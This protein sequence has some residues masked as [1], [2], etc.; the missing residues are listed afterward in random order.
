MAIREARWDC[1][2]CG[3]TGILGRHQACSKCGRSRPA[4]T[5]FYLAEDEEVADQKLVEKAAIG[6]DWVCEFCSSSN[7]AD[8]SVCQSC[9]AP[10]EATSP[11]QQAKEYELG[12]APTAGDMS[13][14]EPQPRPT[15]A[16]TKKKAGAKGLPAALIGVAAFLF[17]CIC[18][19]GAFFIFGGR[20]TSATVSGF[21]WERTVAVEAFGT[22]I[23]EDWSIPEGGREL[24]RSREI[25]SYDQVLDHYETRE[26]QVSEQ[27]QVGERTYVCGQR[28]LGNGFFEDI[29]CSEPVYETQYSTETYQEPIYRQEPVYDTKYTY[30][31]DKWSVSRT[32]RATGSDHSPTWPDTNL[33]SDEREGERTESYTVI[34][35]DENGEDHTLEL[36]F[37]EWR[38]YEAG[39]N[40][41]LKFNALGDL[42]EVD[43]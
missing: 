6:P 20:D 33:S 23:E 12:Q 36:S 17:L 34:F 42:S 30:E 5:K 10:R 4:G 1:Q 32:A 31:I 27:V 28:D 3:T 19:V 38:G 24:D 43:T 11:E 21:Q 39:Q 41:T 7:P 37:E 18:L 26:R 2:Y 40:V 25:R 22:V 29:Q 13:L 8:V 14:D 9:H 15:A 35:T 16:E